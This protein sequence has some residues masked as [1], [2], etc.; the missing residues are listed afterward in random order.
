MA[1][2]SGLGTLLASESTHLFRHPLEALGLLLGFWFF[3]DQENVTVVRRM[4]LGTTALSIAFLAGPNTVSAAVVLWL[5]GVVKAWNGTEGAG[6]AWSRRRLLARP[7]GLSLIPALVGLV[8]YFAFN[9]LRF[10]DVVVTSGYEKWQA[11]L[12]Q[13][14]LRESTLAVSAYLVSP[15]LS[16]FLF[17]PPLLLALVALRQ[18][19]R[20]WP[21]EARALL[22][23]AAAHLALVA[24]YRFW[25]GA[26]S[27]GPRYA[28]VSILLLMPLALPELEKIEKGGSSRWR[29]ALVTTLAV[30]LVVQ[31][32]GLAI[33]V[34]VDHLALVAGG[35]RDAF[36]P[37][38]RSTGR[39]VF[40]P[41]LSP[42]WVHLNELLAGRNVIPWALRAMKQPGLPLAFWAL[43]ALLVGAGAR[44]LWRFYA[45]G[46]NAAA[47]TRLPERL[48]LAL[49]FLIGVGY[50]FTGRVTEPLPA[51]VLSYL[52]DG[53]AAHREGRH[54]M[55]QELYAL[56]LGLEP[57]NK[58][59]VYNLGL[60][61]ETAGQADKAISLF[62]R[63]VALDPGF[64]V[65]SA[66]LARLGGAA[67]GPPPPVAAAKPTAAPGEQE[68]A[69]QCH[70]R[71]QASWDAGDKRAAL[72][73]WEECRRKFPDQAAFVRNVA[74]CR[75]DL[76]DFEGAVRDY[77]RLAAMLP[78][79]VV[80][81]TDLAWALLRA[82]R[83]D[84]ARRAGRAVLDREPG[85]V[86]ARAVLAQLDAVAKGKPK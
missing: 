39:W 35:Y 65:A 60:L 66:G 76:G 2:L 15:T 78:G 14:N 84:E 4:L 59:A 5:Y 31:V 69:G 55:A 70:S 48:V 10:G 57:Q 82:G 26:I 9:H 36:D 37:W 19:L 62:R 86:F 64:A 29:A 38:A 68:D 17:A 52:N 44:W 63:A 41:S 20:R 72:E 21:L 79:D 18:S 81:Q 6:G 83:L 7:A 47:E 34:N 54:V 45:R 3:S 8:L 22:S 28:L 30:G 53:M 42:P 24:S 27:Y 75:Y 56:V 13:F 1:L 49:A 23:A 50:L 40:V 77:R 11:K 61:H 67:P 51:R 43:L 12:F 80:A 85:N 33:Y 46:E 74:R 73:A 25:H 58:Y 32:L 71:A 16:V